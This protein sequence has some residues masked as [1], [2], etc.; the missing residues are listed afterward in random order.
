[1]GRNEAFE[2]IT[3]QVNA[4]LQLSVMPFEDALSEPAARGHECDRAG[5]VYRGH[6]TKAG[7]IESDGNPSRGS[8]LPFV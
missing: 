2:G 5:I 3:R 1:M 6:G 8:R 7:E 4:A